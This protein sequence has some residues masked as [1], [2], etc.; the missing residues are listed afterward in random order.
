MRASFPVGSQLVPRR[1]VQYQYVIL[2]II[3][4]NNTRTAH[5]HSIEL[6]HHGTANQIE[7][8]APTQTLERSNHVAILPR[9]PTIEL[10]HHGS[11]NRVGHP[12]RDNKTLERSNHV[13]FIVL[14]ATVPHG[15]SIGPR[16]I[17]SIMRTL[18]I[19]DG[20][21]THY[22]SLHRAITPRVSRIGLSVST[23]HFGIDTSRGP[24]MGTTPSP[25]LT[26]RA[27]AHP[28]HRARVSVQYIRTTA[29]IRVRLY[30]E[31]DT[32]HQP[33]LATHRT[34]LVQTTRPH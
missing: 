17:G 7:A 23:L 33:T 10:S 27:H 28:W 18:R 20:T 4:G 32:R 8:P 15:F 2:R 13:K 30:T 24:R 5:I 34:R 14:Y 19:S 12:H 11:T 29:H 26:N 31:L 16:K 21:A 9:E 6:S 22:D 3:D 1:I 25:I